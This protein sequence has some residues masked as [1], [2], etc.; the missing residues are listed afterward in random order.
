[1]RYGLAAYNAGRWNI[2]KY[3]LYHKFTNA[4]R[5]YADSILACERILQASNFRFKF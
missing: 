3:G 1:V 5:V 4:G 2:L